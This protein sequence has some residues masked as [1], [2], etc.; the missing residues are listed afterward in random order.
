MKIFLSR[1]TVSISLLFAVFNIYAGLD[2]EITQGV[3]ASVPIAIYPFTTNTN[4]NDNDIAVL[5]K[6]IASDL[7]RCGL[8]KPLEQPMISYA[9][10]DRLPVSNLQRQNIEYV[11]RGLVE[12]KP[13]NNLQVNF[14]LIDLYQLA[15]R[16]DN[17]TPPVLLTKSFP[18]NYNNLR[19]L[20]HHISDLIYEKL[21]GIKGVFSAKIAYVNVK[22]LSKKKREYVLE[23]ADSDGYNPQALVV[24]S[25]P[26]MSPTWNPNGRQL[27]Y[28]TFEGFRS[29][30]KVVDLATGSSKV[31]SSFKGINGAPSWSPDGNKMALV[32]SKENVPKVYILDLFT[33]KL[34]QITF[35][36]SIDT[37]PRW[38]PNGKSLIFTSSRGG[39]PQIYSY[40]LDN[41]KITRLTFDG[42]YNARASFTPDGKKLVM[43]HRSP[44]SDFKIA[45]QDLETFN[46]D[47]LTTSSMDE[48][49]SVSANGQQI[50][51]ATRDGQKGILGEVSID[52]RIKLKRPAR[53]GDVQEPSWSPYL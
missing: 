7:Y 14:E 47:V 18:A 17:K 38:A 11:I 21:T 48:S 35:G 42:N 3:D 25:E 34:E 44:D 6:V 23:I 39:G 4:Q 20:G 19:S 46:L 16:N 53:E 49:P 12:P 2:I 30:I 10:L 1:V 28:V 27:A 32:L 43:V 5:N 24:S 9:S 51:Y 29:K 8:F 22:W 36:P 40:N 15:N 52:G 13:G 33:N 26:L 31:I 45:V 50:V 41:S 37:E